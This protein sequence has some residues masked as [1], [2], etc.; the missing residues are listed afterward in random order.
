MMI[1]CVCVC[2]VGGD[3]LCS[4][5]SCRKMGGKRPQWSKSQSAS[6]ALDEPKQRKSS[7]KI[8]V[9]WSRVPV[10]WLHAIYLEPDLLSEK[11]FPWPV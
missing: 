8:A 10:V 11:S 7:M 6:L 9:L 1:T 4:S 3:I 5:L 2:W